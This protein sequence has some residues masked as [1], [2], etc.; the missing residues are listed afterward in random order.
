MKMTSF[1]KKFVN[2]VA[3]GRKNAER[4]RR[5]LEQ[6]DHASLHDALELGCGIGTVSAFL[7][8]TFS[9]N[10]VGTDIDPGQIELARSSYPE[11]D[12]LRFA[13][14]DA[15]R[16]SFADESFDLVVAYY[17]FHHIPNWSD[18][19]GEIARVLRPEGCLLWVDLTCSG[20]IRRLFAGLKRQYGVYSHAEILAAFRQAGFDVAASDKMSCFVFCHC[21]AL[22]SKGNRSS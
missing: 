8:E 14:E 16:L 13:V 5:R 18:A 11:H 15:S 17:V 9:K 6:I 19:I 10:V 22:L 1:E 7:A 2:R 3:K 20:F 21:D 12:L 4:V